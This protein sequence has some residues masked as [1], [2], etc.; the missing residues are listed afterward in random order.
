MQAAADDS[1]GP[2]QRV[3]GARVALVL[4]LLINLLNYVDRQVLAA[5]EKLIGDDLL[6]GDQHQ[7]Q[8]LGWLATAFLV[9]YMVVSPIFGW[10]ADRYPRWLLVGVG[11]LIWTLASGASG[12][13]STFGILL[14]TRCFVG[15]GE[16]AWGPTA[17]TI[18]ADMYPVKMRGY[19]MS[20][21]YMAI[22]VGSAL[23]YLLGGFM[24]EMHSWRMA[25][26]VVVP[27]G[28]LLGIWAMFM[29]DPPRGMSDNLA[30]PPKKKVKIAD[31]LLLLKNKSYVLD[32]LGMTAMTFA[33]GGMSYYMPRYL[34]WR[35]AGTLERVNMIFGAL[36]VVSGLSATLLGGLAGD[37]LRKKYDGAYFLVS[38]LG[39]L[40][41]F[42]MFLLMIWAPFPMA[43]VFVFLAE[44]CLFF[45][46]GPSNTILANV[47]HPSMRA[48]AFA[49]NIFIIHAFGDAISPPIIGAIADRS[50]LTVGFLV[51]SV[52]MLVGGLFWLWGTKY[53]AADTAAAGK[54]FD[55]PSPSTAA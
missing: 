43:W 33:I 14:I 42:P 30:H 41:G 9:S 12:W 50:S 40:A 28:I 22:P 1:S 39:L 55:A 47:T 38:G 6:P 27:P 44:F 51:V 34:E 7:L 32:S 53:L 8:K 46:T 48:S 31:Y 13:A 2:Q 10:L 37:W 24:G 29:K 11:V 19:V 35:G 54:M 36:T 16:A 25:F 17:P 49:L 18:I 4:L 26:Y 5:V 3:P 23:G 52:L 15:I 45:N 21:F 20:W